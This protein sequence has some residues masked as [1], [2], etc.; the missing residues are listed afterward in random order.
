MLAIRLEFSSEL[1]TELGE[2]CQRFGVVRDSHLWGRFPQSCSFNSPFICNFEMCGVSPEG[3]PKPFSV[4]SVYSQLAGSPLHLLTLRSD[5][6]VLRLAWP[7][8]TWHLSEPSPVL[9]SP[10]IPISCSFSSTFLPLSCSW[11]PGKCLE[12]LPAGEVLSGRPRPPAPSL[13]PQG[14]RTP[15]AGVRNK[16]ARCGCLSSLCAQGR[17]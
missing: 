8:S 9:A 4:C 1:A 2:V 7:L 5:C 15:Q 14:W 16:A 11:P 6:P 10:T 17:G 13:C 3:S 12:T